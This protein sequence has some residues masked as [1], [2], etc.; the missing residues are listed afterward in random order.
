MWPNPEF[1]ADLATFTEEILN[2]K[3]HFLCTEL[4]WNGFVTKK[5]SVSKSNLFLEYSNLFLRVLSL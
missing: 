4:I 5:L 3:P 2:G 1:S